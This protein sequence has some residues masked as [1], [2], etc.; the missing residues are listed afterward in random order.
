MRQMPKYE[1]RDWIDVLHV[2]RQMLQF[3][4]ALGFSRRE[5]HELAIVA[6]ELTSNILKYGIR[7]SIEMETIADGNGIGVAVIAS[8]CGPPFRDL[9]VAL[10]DGHDDQGPIDPMQMVKRGGIGGGLGAVLRLTHAFSVET[11]ATGKKV[12][13]VRYLQRPKSKR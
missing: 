11:Q 4:S 7:G 2:Q 12:Y 3:A 8:D 1:I 6:S 5:C 13:A 9:A 10:Q